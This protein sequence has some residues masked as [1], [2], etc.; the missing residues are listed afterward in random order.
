[1][2]GVLRLQVLT[3]PSDMCIM[4]LFIALHRIASHCNT[5]QIATLRSVI[6]L[7]EEHGR[8]PLPALRATPRISC[9]TIPPPRLAAV[10]SVPPTRTLPSA[11]TTYIPYSRAEQEGS[12]VSGEGARGDGQQ[13]VSQVIGRGAGGMTQGGQAH[14]LSSGPDKSIVLNALLDPDT[15]LV[16][17][18]ETQDKIEVGHEGVE[19]WMMVLSRLQP[20]PWS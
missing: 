7:R 18:V 11:S 9:D 13:G 16:T 5:L 15:L 3:I 1:M 8:D 2:Q 4:Y 19:G 14:T 12:T 10:P 6:R 20:W 17:S